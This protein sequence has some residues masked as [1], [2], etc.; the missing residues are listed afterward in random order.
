MPVRFRD[1]TAGDESGYAGFLKFEHEAHGGFRGA[2]FVTDTRGEPRDFT[3]TRVDVG[4]GFLWRAGDA[5]RRAI[6]ALVKALFSAVAESP[7]LLIAK[8]DELPPQVFVEDIE[9]YVPL[10]RVAETTGA[11]RATTE[12]QE[13][14]GDSLQLLWATPPPEPNTPARR[15]L[16][17]LSSRGLVLE[18]FERAAAGLIEAFKD[19]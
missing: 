18:P 6:S 2:L 19:G 14:L 9:L 8:A 17:T 5:R 3:F 10:V 7:T 4:A 15:V 1:L 13:A 12:T 11:I 16:D